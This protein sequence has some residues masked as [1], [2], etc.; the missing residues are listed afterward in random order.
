M[1]VPYRQKGYTVE[2]QFSQLFRFGSFT[3]NR[4]EAFSDGIFA[5]LDA[6]N[7]GDQG[8]AH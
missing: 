1:P 8:P 4:V 2:K 3:K 5:I 6:F 7:I